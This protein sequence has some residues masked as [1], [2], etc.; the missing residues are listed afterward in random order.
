[1]SIKR[2]LEED[3]KRKETLLTRGRKNSLTSKQ[4]ATV[5]K[6][7]SK[8]ASKESVAEVMGICRS[9]VYNIVNRNQQEI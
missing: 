9:T 3:K 1:M 5:L 8:G 7:I 6:A 4:E 2:I